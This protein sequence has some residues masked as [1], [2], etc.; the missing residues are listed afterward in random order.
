M[1]RRCKVLKGNRRNSVD[2]VPEDEAQKLAEQGLVE[3]LD[4]QQEPELS[5]TELAELTTP[6]SPD[7]ADDADDATCQGTK[8]DGTP[9][10]AAPLSDALYCRHHQ[11]QAQ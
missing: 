6:E 7:D 4:T 2:L 9:C 1:K 11:D 5:T 8:A 10:N 3:I